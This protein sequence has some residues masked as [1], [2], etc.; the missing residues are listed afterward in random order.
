MSRLGWSGMK[1]FR[2]DQIKLPIF[3]YHGLSV[4]PDEV[5]TEL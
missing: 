4:I 1:L 5:Q 3:S 2:R